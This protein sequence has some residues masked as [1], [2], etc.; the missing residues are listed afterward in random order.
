MRG[1]W[2]RG[3]ALIAIALAFSGCGYAR[4]I[5]TLDP[6]AWVDSNDWARERNERGNYSQAMAHYEDLVCRANASM[7]H[8]EQRTGLQYPVCELNMPSDSYPVTFALLGIDYGYYVPSVNAIVYPLGNHQI[9]RHE[10]AHAISTN[11][12]PMDSMCLR[13]IVS[14]AVAELAVF[15]ADREASQ[16]TFTRRA[17]A[18]R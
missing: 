15:N 9:L 11:A 17:R 14:I 13:E 16:V 10:F 1:T 12:K 2:H 5:A 8:A 6:Q 18:T 3:L 7:R 4:I